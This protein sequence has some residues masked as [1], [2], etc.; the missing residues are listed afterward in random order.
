MKILA[1]TQAR[2][3][4]TRL[5]AK[6][7]KMINGESIL[8]IHLKRILCSKLITKLKVATTLETDAFKIVE[9][10]NKLKVEVYQGSVNNVLDR[11]YQT[12][13]P[14]EPNWIVRLTSDCPLIDYVEIDRVIHFAVENDLDYAS[15]T[16][17]P[18]FPDGIDVEVFKFSALEKAL[19]EAKLTSE[20]EHVTPFIWKNSTF[21]NG[22]LFKS[23]C[24]INDVDYSSVRLT[25]DTLEDFQVIEKLVEIIGTDKRWLDYVKVLQ[26]NPNIQKINEKFYRN[27]GYK[28]SILNDNVA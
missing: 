17:K 3:G 23:D 15:N 10:S 12:A 7:L 25:V 8:E 18:T 20:I 19:K 16:L 6:I 26:S 27:E 22:N 24:V 1:I 13:L 4:S 9:I 2:I 14:E 5:P 21:N 11:F 28:K